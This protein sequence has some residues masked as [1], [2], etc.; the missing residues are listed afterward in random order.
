MPSGTLHRTG[1]ST[2]AWW[3]AIA[4][5]APFSLAKTPGLPVSRAHKL[6]PE[7]TI[8]GTLASEVKASQ[9]CDSGTDRRHPL[10]Q[11]E[12]WEK[13]LASPDSV[14]KTSLSCWPS[15]HMHR[16][17]T[18][19]SNWQ[20]FQLC[21]FSPCCGRWKER[22]REKTKTF[23]VRQTRFWMLAPPPTRRTAV[24]FYQPPRLH[25]SYL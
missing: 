14:R 8:T 9:Q 16:L 5:H 23:Q 15:S 3:P 22:G 24:A 2:A 12:S 13:S 19:F 4:P 18:P 25:I 21:L 11:S 20:S 10:L 7:R 17:W 1:L 6:T